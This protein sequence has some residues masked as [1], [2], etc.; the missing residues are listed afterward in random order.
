MEPQVSSVNDLDSFI[1]FL[2]NGLE[3]YSCVAAM[4]VGHPEQW[5]SLFLH[6]PSE[7]GRIKN[8]IRNTTKSGEVFI[9]PAL[10]QTPEGGANRENFKCAN[11]VWADFDGN[12]P[13]WDELMKHPSLV[14]QSSAE[15][16]QHTYWRLNEPIEDIDK[17]EE[18]NRRICYNYGADPAC[19]PS[20]HVLRPP[21]TKN[22]KRETDVKLVY[23]DSISYDSSI[24]DSL[25]PLTKEELPQWTLGELPDLNDVLLSY[26]IPP[27]LKLLLKKE[28]SEIKDRSA[29]LMNAA[30]I[31]CEI[32]MSDVQVF[33][34]LQALDV[35]WEKFSKRK[36]QEKQL[37]K[38]IQRARIKHPDVLP[39]PTA[40][41]DAV[42]SEN[43]L[44]LLNYQQFLNVIVE[45]DWVVENMLMDGGNML[46]AGRSGIG[47]TQLTLQWMKHI[48][49]G[50]DFLGYKVPFAKK[51]GFLSLEMGIP[52]LQVFMKAQDADLNDAERELLS[53]NLEIIPWG[54]SWPLNLP[55]WQENLEALIKER[56]WEGLFVDSIGSAILGNINAS[57]TVQPF[58]NFSDHI[59]KKYGLFLWYIHHT[60][61]AGPGQN[62]RVD[63]D[64]IYGDQYLV[65]RCTSAYG[66][67][68]GKND[69]IKIRNFKNRLAP[70]EQD[71]YIDRT[72]SLNFIRLNE[73]PEPIA[74]TIPEEGG[75][76]DDSAGDG[77]F[78]L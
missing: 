53:Q 76:L 4:P 45:F 19:W 77:K 50:K 67:L 27:D 47:K 20:V 43:P 33:V 78:T 42:S 41:D 30:H 64:D 40:D 10:F 71:Y 36:D 52:D 5:K 12:A 6:Y 58:T 1:E 61:K 72:Q 32:G 13:A 9:S 35:K 62:G 60:R 2:Y 65:N 25:A 29:A 70:T 59:R 7:V 22:H 21:E 46:M 74:K 44:F 38:I 69:T 15:T 55:K 28:K 16:R 11:V 49:L 54:E 31:C 26:A 73:I 34:M 3:G 75:K 39:T 37:V 23:S 56:E 51:V 57:E 8:V 17:H 48:A 63:Q 24:F 14:I 68:P 18:F 66:V